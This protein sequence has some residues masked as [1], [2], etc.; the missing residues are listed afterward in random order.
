MASP[1]IEVA[2]ENCCKTCGEGPHWDVATKS[3]YYVD[4]V[5]GGVAR[6]NSTTGETKRVELDKAVGFAIPTDKGDV[7]LGYDKNICRLNLDGADPSAL[8][9]VHTVEQDKDTRFNDAK[10]DT[11][12]RLWAG[13]MGNEGD[14]PG[15]VKAGQGSLYSISSDLS[16]KHQVGGIDLSNGMDW[17]DDNS[18]MYFIDSVPRKV[19]AFDFNLN[20]NSV[21]NQ[22]TCVDFGEGTMETLGLPDGMCIDNEGKIWV[23]CF[24]ASKVVRFDPETG[25][26]LQEVKLP[27]TNITSVCFGGPNLDELY[28]TCSRYNAPNLDQQPLAGSIFK[29]TGLGVK[30]R[31]PNNFKG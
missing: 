5:C 27:A 3:L 4:I 13:T 24:S 12:G 7:V 21:S 19:Y 30:G 8:T 25:K 10:C 9:T 14:V 29:V 2:I 26:N 11:L 16:I 18:V 23:A 31:A 1:K 20:D 22:R 28:V 17:T 6:W 15:V